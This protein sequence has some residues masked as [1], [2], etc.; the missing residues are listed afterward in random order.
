MRTKLTIQ[1]LLSLILLLG[2]C[3][4]ENPISAD[5]AGPPMCAGSGS[6]LCHRDGRCDLPDGGVCELGSGSDL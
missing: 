6:L 4:T 1:T 5:A 3:S 2:A